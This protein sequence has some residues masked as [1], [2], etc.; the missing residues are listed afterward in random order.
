MLDRARV[1]IGALVLFADGRPF[2]ELAPQ[3]A[4][5]LE[6]T[7]LDIEVGLGTGGG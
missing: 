6:G 1:R 3:A 4:S 7:D 5:Y 2:D